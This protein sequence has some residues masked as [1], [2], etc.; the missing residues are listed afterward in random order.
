M[1]NPS[2]VAALI[3]DFYHE[4]GPMEAAVKA[5]PGSD[6]PID[7]FTDPFA[8]PGDRLA[9][10]EV[11][12]MARE[13][14]LAPPG[15]EGRVEHGAARAGHRRIRSRR[16]RPRRPARRSC[17]ARARRA[18]RVHPARHLPHAP[19]AASGVPGPFQGRASS[20]PGRFLR[21][22]VPR[23]NVL[24]PGGFGRDH[25]PPGMLG[26]GLWQPDRGPGARVRCDRIADAVG[27]ALTA[28]RP[29]AALGAGSRRAATD[30]PATSLSSS[31]PGGR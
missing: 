16:R 13:G 25:A 15:I 5:I 1:T 6:A 24:R 28:A 12:V 11:P 23:R 30:R 18:V 9:D 22:D 10:N 17:L 8:V 26:P 19:R 21:S 20:A 4:P 29:Q 2:G 31:S 3:G 27:S 7:F 14:R